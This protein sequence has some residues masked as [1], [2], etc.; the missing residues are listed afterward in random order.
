MHG[1]YCHCHQ[2]ISVMFLSSVCSPV[3]YFPWMFRI[4]LM[5]FFHSSAMNLWYV[6]TYAVTLTFGN[7]LLFQ[8]TAVNYVE[9]LLCDRIREGLRDV[10][11]L[12]RRSVLSETFGTHRFRFESL[13]DWVIRWFLL[14]FENWLL[15]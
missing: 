14:S 12:R 1:S 6:C 4:E 3:R 10:L 2:Y 7:L 9:G 13:F 11:V 5:V 8:C 15:P